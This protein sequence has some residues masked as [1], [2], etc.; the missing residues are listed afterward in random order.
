[1]RRSSLDDSLLELLTEG[2]RLILIEWCQFL[3]KAF[4]P[5]DAVILKITY[6]GSGRDVCLTATVNTQIR[7]LQQS[8]ILRSLLLPQP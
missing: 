7:I 2:N 5:E 1:M 3:Q 6:A 4:Q 8:P